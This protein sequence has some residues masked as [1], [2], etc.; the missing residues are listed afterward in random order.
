V[1][2]QHTLKYGDEVAF[3]WH[4]V[5]NRSGRILNVSGNFRF[6]PVSDTHRPD[7]NVRSS[8]HCRRPNENMD[9]ALRAAAF[10]LSALPANDSSIF[11]A[12]DGCG[13]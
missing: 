3:E 10:P 13:S 9:S 8:L 1:A 4:G 7:L 11:F 6:R 2:W 5:M 12:S